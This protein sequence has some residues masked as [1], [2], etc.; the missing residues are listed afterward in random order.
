[1][2][3]KYF[4]KCLT[5]QQGTENQK[6]LMVYFTLVRIKNPN[7][8]KCHYGPGERK[9]IIHFWWECKLV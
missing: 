1:M 9:T 2:A 4:S 6:Y 5:S 7:D 8:N 3:N